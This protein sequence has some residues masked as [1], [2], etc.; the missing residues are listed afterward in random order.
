MIRPTVPALLLVLSL[1]GCTIPIKLPDAVTCR[2]DGAIGYVG[3]R[4]SERIGRIVKDKTQAT[5]VRVVPAGTAVTQEFRSGRV[6]IAT[7]ET[8]IVT[9]I[10]CG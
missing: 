3:Q 8:N 10:Y 6:N 7:D 1:G 4:Y 2:A 5:F 9:R